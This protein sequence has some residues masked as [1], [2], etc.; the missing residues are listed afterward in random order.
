MKEA[1][2]TQWI[3]VFEL[4]K[5][6]YSATS[7]KDFTCKTG[8]KHRS[9]GLMK[10][11]LSLTYFSMPLILCHSSSCLI[12]LSHSLC[13]HVLFTTVGPSICPPLHPSPGLQAVN[14]TRR[15]A[16]RDAGNNDP[17]QQRLFPCSYSQDLSSTRGY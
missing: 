13:I 12:C 10:R 8:Q 7:V 3:I 15:A 9:Y 2:V 4:H 17:L 1:S 11:L 14:V 16:A 6:Q 5:Q